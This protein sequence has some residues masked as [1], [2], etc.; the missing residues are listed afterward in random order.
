MS[1]DYKALQ[2]RITGIVQGV[3]FRDWT[4]SEA[5][6][7]GLR[8]WVRNETDGSV[9]AL[10]V[11]SDTA[12]ATMLARLHEGPSHSRVDRVASEPAA[13]AE[14]PADFRISR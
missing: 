7:L 2:V 9:T 12:V 8:G 1:D 4:R 5:S 6:R 10:L 14:R 3:G 13:I 11:G